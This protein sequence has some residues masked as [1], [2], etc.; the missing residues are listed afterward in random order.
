MEQSP[1][2]TISAVDSLA[3]VGHENCRLTLYATRKVSDGC[4]IK[5]LS[6]FDNDPYKVILDP[7]QIT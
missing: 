6:T 1:V 3:L 7:S 2:S 4:R 5:P